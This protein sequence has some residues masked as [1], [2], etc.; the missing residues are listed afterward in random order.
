MDVVDAVF[1]DDLCLVLVA[2]TAAQLDTAIHKLLNAIT[3]VFGAL[4]LEINFAPGETECFL[5]FRGKHATQLYAKYRCNGNMVIPLDCGSSL[6]VVNRYK[7]LGSMLCSNLDATVDARHKLSAA[8][9]PHVWNMS[10]DW[11]FL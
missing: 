7:H 6:M 2:R 9:H 8:M 4:A 11:S 3:P 5:V 10:R 1:V